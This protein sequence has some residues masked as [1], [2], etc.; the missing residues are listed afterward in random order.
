ME[1]SS[2]PMKVHISQTTQ[3]VLPAKYI[4][5]ERGDLDVKGKGAMKTYW[6]HKCDGR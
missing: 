1:S 2:Q 4:T 3:K 6:L 5:E